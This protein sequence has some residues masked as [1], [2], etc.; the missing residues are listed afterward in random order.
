LSS[1]NSLLPHF[2]TYVSKRLWVLGALFIALCA[3]ALIQYRWISQVTEAERQ[4]AKTNLASALSA[5]ESDFD[6]EIT[7]A[8]VTFQIPPGNETD[9]A[10]RYKEWIHLSPYPN[11][12][13]GIYIAEVGKRE[14]L[15]RAVIPGEPT[16]HSTEWQ[17]ILP[18]LTS[19]PAATAASGAVSSSVGFQSFTQGGVALSIGLFG[20]LVMIEGNPAF[21][22][23]MMPEFPAAAVIRFRRAEPG[24]RRVEI[25]GSGLPAPPMQWA[26]VIL[27]GNYI[28]TTFLPILLGVHFPNGSASSYDVLVV[29][30]PATGASRVVFHSQSAPAENLFAKP[31]QS[32]SLFRIRLD[33]FLAPSTAGAPILGVG[34]KGP[35]LTKA[36]SLSEILARRSPNCSPTEPALGVKSEGWWEMLVRNREGSLDQAITTFRRR[37]LLLSGGVLLVLALGILMLTISAE[38]ARALAE[39]QAEFVLGVSHELRTPLTVIRVAADNLRKGMA[40]SSEQAH[41]YGEIISAHAFELS[42]MIEETLAFARMQSTR[43]LGN[44]TPVSAEQIVSDSLAGCESALREAGMETDVHLVPDLPLIEVD[45]RLMKRCLENLIQNAIKYARQGRWVAIR[46]KKVNK[47]GGERL[48]IS[49]EDRGPGISPVDLPHIFEPF[50]RGKHG[51]TSQASGIGL[52]LS[53]VKRIVEAHHGTVEVASSGR[54]GTSVAVCLPLQQAQTQAPQG[55]VK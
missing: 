41:K 5:L 38:R 35:L 54:T 6:I 46:T 27:D 29:N 30:K 52:G 31:D 37:N 8:F 7:R 22:F 48:Q 14:P 42:K 28:K 2:K 45:V 4:R 39:M 3:L 12:V 32:I 9:Y 44:V 53:L 13:R 55:V 40:E 26:V 51:G 24:L 47:Q 1:V 10:G 23:P 16:I 18:K 33:C 15:L 21:V 36:D 20:P 17:E 34:P 25:R 11:L 43:A 49:V 19:P 50:Y